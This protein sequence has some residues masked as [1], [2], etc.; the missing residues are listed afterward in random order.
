MSLKENYER[1]LQSLPSHVQLVA[2]SKTHPAQS[3]QS[4][5]DL[6]HRVFAENKVQELLL[7]K[8]Q[9][10][11][12]IKWHLIGHLQTNKVKQIIGFISLIESV[13]SEKLL[14]EINRQAEKI[15]RQV[16]LLLQVRIAQ[17]ETKF[18]LEISETKELFQRIVQGEFPHIVLKG[19]MGMASFTTDLEQV[20]S[21]F[22]LLK[23]LYDQLSRIQPLELLSMGMSSDYALAIERGSTSVRIGSALFGE[24]HYTN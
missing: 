18:G 22:A 16:P 21:E 5:Y 3:I 15:G 7:K 23:N 9:L 8:E 11:S 20:S 6:G 17:E 14:D 12:D 13:D 24:R 10:P 19:L 4:L 2:V 1:I